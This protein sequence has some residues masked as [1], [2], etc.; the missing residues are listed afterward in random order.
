MDRLPRDSVERK[1]PH[2]KESKTTWTTREDVFRK[3]TD[4]C[5]SQGM[6]EKQA[7]E[8]RDATS[9]SFN[10]DDSEKTDD[11]GADSASSG[12]V[13]LQTQARSLG[14]PMPPALPPRQDL[15]IAQQVGLAVS[16]TGT[17]SPVVAQD[18]D[19]MGS[20]TAHG[21][22][23]KRSFAESTPAASA[24]EVPGPSIARRKMNDDVP[25]PSRAIDLD[26]AFLEKNADSDSDSLFGD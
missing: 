10:R 22:K 16:N 20:S 3:H 19:V 17:P 24:D 1:C 14:L 11:Y 9:G 7:T 15:L 23:R 5:A 12:R 18:V 8:T 13:L 6:N 4:K 2:C 26:L 21:K 25:P